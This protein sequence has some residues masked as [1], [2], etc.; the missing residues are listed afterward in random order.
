MTVARDAKIDEWRFEYA[1]MEEV[2]GG[3][4]DQNLFLL[5]YT[6]PRLIAGHSGA[7][8]AVAET[9]GSV[10]RFAEA[11][12]RA[13][14]ARAKE[15]WLAERLHTGT[16]VLLLAAR[17]ARPCGAERARLNHALP[18]PFSNS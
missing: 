12:S 5:D 13:D 8:R 18:A 16:T 15:I 1:A 3:R 6:L 11:V 7:A 10:E 9:D 4:W 14:A 2:S 17:T